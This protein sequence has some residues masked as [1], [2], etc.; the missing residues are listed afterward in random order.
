MR[1]R[2]PRRSCSPGSRPLSR[3]G[4]SAAAPAPLATPAAPTGIADLDAV[5]A[6]IVAEDVDALLALVEFTPQPCVTSGPD[7]V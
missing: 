5:I 2:W 1:S 7:G 4:G 6:H 3:L